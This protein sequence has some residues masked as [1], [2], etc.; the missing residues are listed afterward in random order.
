MASSWPFGRLL[1]RLAMKAYLFASC[2]NGRVDGL[3][4][5]N[6]YAGYD[7]GDDDEDEN[8]Y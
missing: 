5:D 3:S 7:C 4:A 8:G 1:Q 6:D 2:S